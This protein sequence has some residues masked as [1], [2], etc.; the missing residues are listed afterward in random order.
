MID[1]F[2]CSRYSEKE[3]RNCFSLDCDNH[4]DIFDAEK[5][6]GMKRYLMRGGLS[7]F[8]SFSPLHVLANNSIGDNVGNLLYAYGC[9]RT[10]F[11]ED[12]SIDLDYYRAEAGYSKKE[13][14]AINETYD[15]YLLPMADA[16]RPDFKG[17]LET[18]TSI[19]RQL[20]IP[21]YLVGVGVRAPY[22]PNLQDGLPVDR[23]A[24]AFVK[25]ILDHSAM[26][27]LRGQITGDYLKHLGFR[28]EIDYT[29]IG[30]PSMYARGRKLP[31][32]RTT[33][34]CPDS[35]VV[36]S[37][38]DQT[39]ESVMQML[40]ANLDRYPNHYYVGQHIKE[41]LLLY[42]GI[43][44]RGTVD[45]L[46]PKTLDHRLYREDRTHFFVNVPSWFDW[47]AKQDFVIGGRLHGNVAGVLN[48]C[49]PLF[50][51]QD[52][53][54]RELLQYHQFPIIP[55]Q[56]IKST[57]DF[58]DLAARVDLGSH[59]RC[60]AQNFDHFVDFLEKN[61]LETVYS[62]QRDRTQTPLDQAMAAIAYEPEVVSMVRCSP[63]E[64]LQRCQEYGLE[65]NLQ[66]ISLK[67]TIQTQIAQKRKV[68]ANC[69]KLEEENHKLTAENAKLE[70][71]LE[72]T[73]QDK[74]KLQD[75]LHHPT[76]VARYYA[77]A[78]VRRVKKLGAPKDDSSNR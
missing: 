1:N 18:Y 25:A 13:I 55:A 19:I 49:A 40:M 3:Q 75:R 10:L 77:G 46:F 41:L 39:P 45:P 27:G 35:R 58:A 21:V 64:G 4:A 26:V 8:D 11:T 23:E 14:D 44:Y 29:V 36:V 15:A 74:Q 31:P 66:K 42:T 78:V 69:K 76:K 43:E 65:M 48:G 32:L 51:A 5:G 22:E 63:Q 6:F 70:Q 33:K 50:I 37:F 16:F 56:E 68:E 53:R 52:A 61:G 54:M 73:M 59:L 47:M 12:T 72:K 57:D 17:K 60:H 67:K 62:G 20:K 9:F 30:C 38:S 34:L 2:L 24:K 71:K 28:E 7:V